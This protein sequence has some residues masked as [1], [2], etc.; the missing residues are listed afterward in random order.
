MT[1]EGEATRKISV[2]KREANPGENLQFFFFNGG[3][4]SKEIEW[5]LE[6]GWKPPKKI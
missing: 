1:H 2:E 4:A 5:F 6:S 3:A